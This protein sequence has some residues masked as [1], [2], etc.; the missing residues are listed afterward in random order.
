M[1][2]QIKDIVFYG[3][4]GEM[5]RLEFAHGRLNIIT[6]A[7]KTGK[8]A[9]IAVLEYCFGSSECQIPEGIMRRAVAWAGVRLAVPAGE[10]FIA[11]RLP[12]PGRNS[13]SDVHYAVGNQ[14]ELPPADQLTQTTNPNALEGLLAAHAGIGQN[15]HDPPP[16][17]TRLPLQAGIVHALIYCFQHQTEI[18][19]NRHLFHKQ[20]EQWLPQAIK[21]TIPY[22]LGAVDDDYVARMAELRRLRR[23]L[24]G[25]ERKLGEYDAVRGQGVT[26]AQGLLAEATDLGLRPG[27]PVSETWDACLEA[28]RGVSGASSVPEEEQVAVEGDEFRRLQAEREDITHELRVVRDQLEAAREL[29]ADRRGYSQEAHAQIL[30]LKSIELFASQG[31]EEH[32][33]ATCPLCQSALLDGDVAPSVHAIQSALARLDTQVRHVEDRAP[34]MQAVVTSLEGKV[35]DLKSHLRDNRERLEAIQRESARL[36]QYRDR[37]ARRA[38]ILGRISL[39][40]ESVPQL[41]D[42]SVLQRQ[43]AD[44]QAQVTALEEE[45]SDDTVQERVQSVLSI[46]SRDMNRWATDLQLEHAEFPLRLDLRRLTVVADGVDGPIPMDRMGS[47]EN[48]VGYHLIAHFALHHWFVERQRPVPRFIFI[49]Q[50]SQVYFPEDENWQRQENGTGGVG[51]DRQKVRSMYKLA[52]DVV[53]LLG[54]QFQVIVTDHANINE[55][56]FQ[57][58]VV[59]RWREGRKLIPTEWDASSDESLSGE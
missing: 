23:E 40:L 55:Q 50:P 58:C 27:Q 44:L 7:S 6:G 21:D 13:S 5:R 57:D 16:G 19:S 26:V 51:E 47:G 59:E 1:S 53:Q 54:G 36:Q 22:F 37:N 41:E 8:T 17:Q 34:Q 32:Q 9:L 42:G 4:N 11:R 14:V 12:A 33:P 43:I 25:I 15:R 28:L 39:Y 35:A 52:Y 24:R 56:W 31:E 49:D 20:S 10:A 46:I 38:H 3:H 45:L 48:W 30:R 2:F 29:T 18:D